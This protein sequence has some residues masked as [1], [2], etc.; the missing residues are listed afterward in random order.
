[1]VP[2]PLEQPEEPALRPRG[3]VR[4]LAYWAPVWV[5]LV[6]LAQVCLRGLKPTLGESARLDRAEAAL[7]ERYDAEVERGRELERLRRALGDPIYL[8]RER[9]LFQ[10]EDSPLRRSL[11]R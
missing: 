1:M 8:E 4:V 2:G 9:R 10:A 11:D 6:L 3:P 7:L 5:P